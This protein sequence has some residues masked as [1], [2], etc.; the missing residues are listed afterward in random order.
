MTRVVVAD[1]QALVREGFRLLLD[2][3]GIEVVGEAEDGQVA[4][5]QIRSTRP[6]VALMDI[7]MPE[8]DGIE[9]TRRAAAASPDT[10]VLVL[11]TFD[12]D[13]YVF[14]AFRAGASG[15]L[16]KSVGGEQLVDGIRSVAAGESLVAPEITLRLLRRFLAGPPSGGMPAGSE[17]MSDREVQV[18]GLIARGYSNAEIA[19]ELMIGIATVKTHVARVLEKLEVRDRV[20]VVIA[21]YESG[22]VAPGN[23]R[24]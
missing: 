9:A 19:D 14:E 12:L 11:T 2:L 6:D 24:P 3:A 23:E 1:D 17:L 4:L 18:M 13:E 7:R 21:A 8:M 5:D 20:Q 16:L 22:F 10:K 15:F